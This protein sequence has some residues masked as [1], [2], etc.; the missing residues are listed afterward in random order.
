MNKKLIE[1]TVSN[2]V[3]K[4][5]IDTEYELVDVEYVKEGPFMYLRIYIDKTGGISIDDCADISRLVNKEL[6][7]A[8]LIEDHYFLEVSSPGIDRAFKKDAD[9]QKNINSE[10]EV[11]LYKPLDGKKL[12]KGILLEK[13]EDNIKINI[14]NNEIF[15]DLADISKINKAVDIF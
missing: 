1:S 8:D 9:F 6:D 15:I 10:V 5:I 2:L 7:K 4:L 14:N 12:L 11:K 13:N 3:E